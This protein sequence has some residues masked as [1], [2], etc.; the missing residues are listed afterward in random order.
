MD[1]LL[2]TPTPRLSSCNQLWRCSLLHADV[3]A[4]SSI[5]ASSPMVSLATTCLP[6]AL[7]VLAGSRV[8]PASSCI[9]RARNSLDALKLPCGIHLYYGVEDKEKVQTNSIYCVVL[10][11]NWRKPSRLLRPSMPR[12][13]RNAKIDRGNRRTHLRRLQKEE[14][15]REVHRPVVV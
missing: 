10:I 4:L 6:M 2:H 15:R 11:A 13:I 12:W 14:E 3:L 8:Y 7:H 5:I 9:Q 1:L